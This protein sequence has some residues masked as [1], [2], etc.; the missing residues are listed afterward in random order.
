MALEEDGRPTKTGKYDEALLL[1]LPHH[2]V[3][4]PWLCMLKEKRQPSLSLW[5]HS[6]PDMIKSRF[7]IVDHIV[8]GV[9][10]CK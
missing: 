2:A 3:L 8:P 7:W 10:S 5:I 6:H 4:N 9:S 1:D